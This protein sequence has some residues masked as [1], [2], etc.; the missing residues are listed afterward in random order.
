MSVNRPDLDEHRGGY[1][2]EGE[3]RGRT[4]DTDYV[5]AIT[6]DGAFQKSS[7]KLTP[8]HWL[9]E[10]CVCVGWLTKQRQNID[11]AVD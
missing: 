10:M 1:E 3:E 6:G 9:L 8:R 2:A 11:A 5:A 7:G 4:G